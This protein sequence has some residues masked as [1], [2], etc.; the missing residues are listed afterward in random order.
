MG[1]NLTRPELDV[2]E[3]GSVAKENKLSLFTAA[4]SATLRMVVPTIGLFLVGLT[5]D[6]ILRQE[7]F[8]A[9]IGAIAGFLI[10]AFLIYLQIRKLKIKGQDS[11][12]NDSEGMIKPKTA[13]STKGKQ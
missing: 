4:V 13:E 12:I 11:L 8:Y 7:A 6:F 5:T 1:R 10:A 3:D 2:I 9:I